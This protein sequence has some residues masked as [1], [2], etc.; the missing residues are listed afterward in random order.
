[1]WW[2]ENIEKALIKTGLSASEASRRAT[3][4]PNAIRDMRAGREPGID[5]YQ[6]ICKVLGIDFYTGLPGDI[7]DPQGS[8]VLWGNISAGG[9]ADPADGSVALANDYTADSTAPPVDINEAALT[10]WGGLMAL[11]VS[12]SS[13][14]PTYFNGDIVYIYADDPKRHQPESLVGHDC[15]VTLA[16]DYQGEAYL[17]RLRWADNQQQGFFN[18]ESVNLEWPVMVNRPVEFVYPIRYV[19]HRL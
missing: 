9:G 10:K 12:G 15:A 11:R 5:R 2:L 16:G 14:Q 4:S 8:V 3:G 19:K 1:M 18:L 6:K 13:M 17:K 7:A